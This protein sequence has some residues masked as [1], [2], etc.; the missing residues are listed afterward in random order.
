MNAQAKH[1]PQLQK[2]ETRLLNGLERALFH[3]RVPVLLLFL[4]ATLLLGYKALSLRAD[5]SFTRMIPTSHPYIQNYLRFEEV[6]RPQS[7]VLRIIVENPEGD[8]FTPAFLETLRE[9]TDKVFYIPGV[10][11]GK[12]KSLWT[13]NAVWSEVTTDGVR[14]GR[15]IP[16]GYDGSER[17]LAQVRQNILRAN[18]LGSLVANDLRSTIIRVPLLNS[19]PQSGQPLD[20]GVFSQALE[21]QVREHFAGKGV[22]IR[23]IGFAQIIGDLLAAASNIALFFAFTV[24]LISALLLLYCRC[25]R[26]TAV[27][28]A[29]CLLTVVCQLGILSL[30]GYGLDPY[31]ILVP[32]LIFAIGISHA[33]QNINLMVSEAAQGHGPIDA[34]RRTFRALFIPGTTALLADAV[35]FITLLVI[36]IGVIKQLAI[37]ASIGVFVA[38]F[39]KMFLLPVLMSYVG[40]SP[41]AIARQHARANASWPVFRRLAA[42]VEP[43][44]A[45]PLVLASLV[46]LTIGYQARKDLQ[47][48]DLDGGAPEFRPEARYN[49]DNAY[50][51]GHYTTSTDVY[52]VMFTTPAEQCSRFAAA[53]LAHQFQRHMRDIEGVESVQSLY[54]TM[55]FNILARNEGNPKWAELSR[56]QYVM[57]NARSGVPAEQL[58]SDCS[59]VPISL[60]LRDHKAQTLSRVSA[61][62]EQFDQHHGG[63]DYRLLQAAG[64]AGIEAATNNVIRHS[65]KVMLV[66]VFVIISLVVLWEFKSL[67]V[68]F[69]LMA[70]LYLSTVLCEAVMAKMGLGVKVATLPVIALGVGIGVDYGIYLYSRMENFLLQG[71]DLRRAYFEAL[72]TTGTSVAFTGITLA[73][74]VSTWAFS[75]LKF[76]ADMG[77][78]LVLL[79]VWNMIGA[80]VL[81]PAL[82]SLLQKRS[83][84]AREHDELITP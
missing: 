34:S 16:D 26:S 33:V 43:R 78:L 51:L 28:V 84:P 31:S 55:R 79:F 38:I 37:T 80:L 4:L 82:I 48:G 17:A 7:N 10:D 76:Q 77:V 24:V 64:N 63:G 22:T 2:S 57:N 45:I 60:Y 25:W 11:R 27:T 56:D 30:L 52:V 23:V 20:Y 49:Q 72:K 50:L 73:L 18:L 67:K 14:S 69:A 74:G 5:A 35:G 29:T 15:V 71:M 65:E 6:L 41:A 1:R 75:S 54:D 39:T 62:V 12:L 68:T 21:Q 59:L 58:N 81:M 53:D 13:P 61:A 40:V 36:D 83:P 70:P 9:V 46:L 42:V 8:I 3:N 47:I 19:D 66:L 32:F 44:L